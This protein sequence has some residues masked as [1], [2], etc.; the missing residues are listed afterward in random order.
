MLC[1]SLASGSGDLGV[2]P[3]LCKDPTIFII[4]EPTAT[5]LGPKD[6]K[7]LR[8]IVASIR[9]DAVDATSH[10]TKS[11]N[12]MNSILAKIEANTAGMDDAILLDHRGFVSEASVTNIF[13]VKDGKVS[14][15]SSA[16]GILHG[17]TRERIIELCSDL[18]LYV[19]E[20]DVT[21]FDLLTADEVFL[22]GTKAEVQAVGTISG[23][24]IGAGS[25]G[26][27]TKKLHQEFGKV[28]LR[29][30]EGTS[31]YEAESVSI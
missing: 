13:L 21:P 18:G 2:D 29:P 16:A 28:V 5:S 11:L 27:L 25:V 31:V 17:I 22:V 8:V 14:T 9:R 24:K 1:P 6:P 4:A 30:K 19:H 20:R 7:L 3:T 23:T 10:E 12:Y 15:P 26:P